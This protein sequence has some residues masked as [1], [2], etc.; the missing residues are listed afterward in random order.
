MTQARLT[1]DELRGKAQTVRGL[2]NPGEL[3]ATLMHEHLLWDIRTPAM[4]ADLDQ[5]PELC[6]CNYFACNYGTRK[7]PNNLVFVD[8]ELATER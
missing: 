5:G 4:R 2:V 8:R 7:A 6:L 3:G 1:R